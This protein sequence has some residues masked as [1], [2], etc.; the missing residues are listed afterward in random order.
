MNKIIVRDFRNGDWYWVNK[1]VLEHPDLTASNQAVYHAL[2]YF[3][4][5]RT[6]SCY[7]TIKKISKLTH[8]HK[9]T[10]SK[11]IKRLE[12]LGFI[13]VKRESGMVN[14]Y[15][16]LSLVES[17]LS[18]RITPRKKHT[19]TKIRPTPPVNK[20]GLPPVNKTP[21]NTN[22]NNTNIT[23]ISNGK[24]IAGK[25]IND[26]IALFEPVNPSFERLFA[27]K[28]QRACLERLAKKYGVE[29]ISKVIKLLPEISSMPYSP[30]VT[31]P[32]QLEQKLGEIIIF[33]RKEREKGGGTV[34]A[35]NVK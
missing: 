6:Q 22:N 26:L 31:T 17:K 4:N 1:V 30:T 7:P 16:L 35:R 11:S 8:L 5:N 33:L 29:K 20:G 3:A 10:V 12:E 13:R 34:D 21:N 23:I 2:A 15:E 28:T 24:S 19:T 27:N 32:Y 18:K 9:E 25:E 14:E